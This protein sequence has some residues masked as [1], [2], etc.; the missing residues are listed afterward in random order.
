M[1]CT[2]QNVHRVAVGMICQ[3]LHLLGRGRSG[4]ETG[5]D[6][7]I[8]RN[9]F[10]ELEKFIPTMFCILHNWHEKLCFSGIFFKRALSDARS[11]LEMG[12]CWCLFYG[13]LISLTVNLVYICQVS[14]SPWRVTKESLILCSCIALAVVGLERR[15]K[16]QTKMQTGRDEDTDRD[17]RRN[18][19]ERGQERKQGLG[20]GWGY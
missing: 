11:P 12:S 5:E 15:K 16:T 2:E 8:R 13:E 3:N 10:D 6:H 20:S 18:R 7:P 9:A 19:R 17:G 14:N 1:R 4:Y